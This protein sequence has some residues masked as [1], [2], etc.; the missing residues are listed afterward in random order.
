MKLEPNFYKGQ[1]ALNC[2]AKDIENAIEIYE[3]CEQNAI[4]GVLSKNYES[5]TAAIDDMKHYAKHLNNAVS[6]GLGA[7]DPNQCYMV[8][9]II[10]EYKPQHVNQVFTSVA[11]ARACVNNDA[12]FINS[13]ISPSGVPGIVKISTGP[14]SSK[15]KPALVD[16]NTAIKMIIE[17]G[18]SSVKFFPMKGLETIEEYKVVCKACANANLGIEPTGGIT[19]SNFEQI[20]KIAYDNGVKKIIPHVYSSII[21]DDGKTNIDD[22]KHLYAIIK[23]IVG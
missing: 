7:G 17:M 23:D 10:K 13:L 8:N 1:I 21:D 5:T 6:V 11:S 9:E 20:C 16:I 15:E 14:L 3:A 12:T 18:G 19:T 4:I 22:V 2:L